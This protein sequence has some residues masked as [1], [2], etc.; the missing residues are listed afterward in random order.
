MK[1]IRGEI[2]NCFS[3]GGGA[4]QRIIDE[5]LVCDPG[6]SRNE[7][8]EF[9]NDGNAVR[10]FQLYG[11]L[12]PI[13]LLLIKTLLELWHGSPSFLRINTYHILSQPPSWRADC[14]GSPG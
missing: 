2:H 1:R 10:F 13:Q 12:D 4:L 7:L 9:E 8:A 6:I 14:P 5:I 3:V 11:I